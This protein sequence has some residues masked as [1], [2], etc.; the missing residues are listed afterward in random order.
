MKKL[1]ILFIA[2]FSG[3][4]MTANSPKTN[5]SNQVRAKIVKLLESAPF[6]VSADVNAEVEFLITKKGEIVVINVSS[7]NALVEDY[8]KSKLNYQKVFVSTNYRSQF[9]KMPLKIVKKA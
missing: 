6:R 3:F 2:L 4:V 9:F 5:Y 7:K 1:S 8:V